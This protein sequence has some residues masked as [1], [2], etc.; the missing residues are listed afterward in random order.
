MSGCGQC[1]RCW[2]ALAVLLAWPAALRADIVHL[3]D[4]SRYYGELVSRNQREV[5]F[6]VRSAG[7]R[8]SMLRTFSAALVARVELT[9][10]REPPSPAEAATQSARAAPPRT[11]AAFPD[12]AAAEADQEQ[13]LREAFELLDDGAL[14]AALRALQMAVLDA[15]PD[16]LPR[17][18]A[19]CRDTRGTALDEVLAATRVRV[20]DLADRGRTFR[21]DY[22][23][24]YERTALGRILADDLNAR[25]ATRYDGRRVSDWAAAPREYT[26]LRSDTRQ[27]VS[28]AARAAALISA[29]LR[30]DPTVRDDKGAR[31][32]LIETRQNLGRLAAHCLA[33]RGY[34]E[35]T[36]DRPPDPADLEAQ[37]L[38]REMAG[39]AG[40]P[41]AAPASAPAAPTPPTQPATRPAPADAARPGPPR[42]NEVPTGW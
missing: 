2:F 22:A 7:G 35:P 41:G 24:P 33:L 29:R 31:V 38:A 25:L 8:G 37:R 40:E 5:V 36:G 10:A 32:H 30:F 23:T 26:E 28:D 42:S 9:A 6:R 19:L 11:G 14:P 34:T 16:V 27:L 18:E 15:P 4:G 3:R 21:L 13:I 39:A 17:L 12:S 20:A 1:S